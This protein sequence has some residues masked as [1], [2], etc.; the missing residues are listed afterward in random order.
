MFKLTP[1]RTT[2]ARR[3]DFM[4]FTDMLDDFF[5]APFRSL[6]HDTFKIDVEE[7]D[8]TYLIKADLPGVKKDELKVS[9]DDQTLAIEV[10]RDEKKEDEDKEKNYLHRERRVSSMRR[11]IHLPDVDPQK[12]KAK[13][14]DGVLN[15]TA[16]KSEV[17][18]EGYVVD[19]E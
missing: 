9:Y 5:N 6:R 17:Q 10:H 7:K 15:I 19:V 4:D 1:F 14:E 8:N 12:V 16:E 13:L 2:P 3:D 11:A 18:D